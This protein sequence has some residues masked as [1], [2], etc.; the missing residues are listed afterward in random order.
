MHLPEK[1]LFPEHWVFYDGDLNKVKA[2]IAKNVIL[3][4]NMN[5]DQYKQYTVKFEAFKLYLKARQPQPEVGKY[6]VD[7]KQI[8]SHVEGFDLDKMAEKTL[9]EPIVKSE[10]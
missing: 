4:K 3:A 7:Y 10:G 5:F 2:E 6:N 9:I 8:D 1:V